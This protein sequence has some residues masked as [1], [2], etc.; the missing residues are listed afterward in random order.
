MS[1]AIVT[2]ASSGMGEEFCRRIDGRGY[3]CIWMIARNTE[4]MERIA[5][6][7]RTPCKVIE[8]D[9]TDREGL[10]RLSDIVS[11]ERPDIGLLVCNAGVGYIGDIDVLSVEDQRRMVDLNINALVSMI[12]PM[13]G[14]MGRGSNVIVLCSLS[15]YLPMPHLAVYSSTKAFVR[16]YCDA[17]RG[18]LEPKGIHVLEVSPGWVDTGF[19]DN[20]KGG[21]KVP[22]KVFNGMVSREDVVSKA[23]S[24]MDKGRK[25]SQV[26]L[27][28]RGISFLGDHFRGFALRTWKGY[29]R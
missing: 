25:R 21:M 10:D 28:T 20:C 6:G 26:G 5:E 8:C 3:D 22:D 27:R 13:V 7:L 9:L 18:E 15:A 19:I 24:D 11:S 1:I 14:C 23:M 12:P 2:G 4:R 29:W 17:I 16:H